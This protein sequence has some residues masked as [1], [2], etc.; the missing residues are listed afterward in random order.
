MDDRP[1]PLNMCFSFNLLLRRCLKKKRFLKWCTKIF[2]YILKQILKPISLIRFFLF[3]VGGFIMMRE[4]F[5]FSSDYRQP[6][7]PRNVCF[8]L[9]NIDYNFQ[10]EIERGIGNCHHHHHQLQR[11]IIVATVFWE[12]SIKAILFIWSSLE[13][14]PMVEKREEVNFSND[15]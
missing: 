15:C 9:L 14:S 10:R 7:K 6:S 3:V 2:A 12:L 11:N 13:L 8:L 1:D 5:T 4:K